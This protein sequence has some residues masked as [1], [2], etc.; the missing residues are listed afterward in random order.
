MLV[1]GLFEHGILCGPIAL[2][3]GNGLAFPEDAARIVVGPTEWVLDWIGR[4]RVLGQPTTGGTMAGPI[5]VQRFQSFRESETGQEQEEHHGGP[6]RGL[7]VEGLRKSLANQGR[8]R[9][10]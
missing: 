9:S 8:H 3:L 7:T 2:G 1:I 5:G 4:S 10:S 6:S